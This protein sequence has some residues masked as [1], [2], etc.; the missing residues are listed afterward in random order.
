MTGDISCLNIL[1]SH[2]ALFVTDRIDYLTEGE[3][4]RED[5]FLRVPL[6]MIFLVIK[7]LLEACTLMPL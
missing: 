3:R 7:K 1:D 5:D 4:V 6:L 2:N